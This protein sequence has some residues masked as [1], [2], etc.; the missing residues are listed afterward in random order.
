[1]SRNATWS[2]ALALVLIAS[3]VLAFAYGA[4][5]ALGV[6]ATQ[7]VARDSAALRQATEQLNA[8]RA[9][10]AEIERKVNT[11]SQRL[12]EIITEE[13][14]TAERLN[15]RA[16]SMYRSGDAGFIGLLLGADSFEEFAARWDLLTR[17]NEEDAL[18]LE[19]L[20]KLR[21]QANAEAR[22]LLKLQEQQARAVAQEAREVAQARKQLAT[23][24]AALAT[25]EARL[26]S[27][28][29]SA[30]GSAKPKKDS[31]QKLRGSGAWKTALASHYSRT[32]TGRGAS[33]DRIGPYSMMVAHKSLP[34]GTLIEFE[35]KGRR[36]VAKVA[37]RGPYSGGRVFDLGPGVVRAL[38]FNGVHNV[39]YR[40]IGR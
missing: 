35:Y 9:R 37:D 28:S 18:D 16:R 2:A 32:F 14:A 3:A 11:A 23:S 13:D 1:M 7:R 12:D 22:N 17:M 27:A 24:K 31:T 10:S 19:Q 34:F 40:I 21:K 20:A 36:A 39:K 15:A 6:T 29:R 30:P 4:T 8:A 33:G 25:F 26:A 5:P 38:N